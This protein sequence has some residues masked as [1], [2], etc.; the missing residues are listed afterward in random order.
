MNASL[1]HQ[2]WHELLP[3]LAN[4]TL[5]GAERARVEEHLASCLTCRSEL[6]AEQRLL[7]A[8]RSADAEAGQADD[9][10]V[11]ILARA[12]AAGAPRAALVPLPASTRRRW[13]QRIGQ[14]MARRVALVATLSAVALGLAHFQAGERVNVQRFHTLSEDRGRVVGADVL[15]VAFAPGVSIDSVAA[16]LRAVGAEVVSGPNQDHVFT[17]RVPSTAVASAV[18]TLAARDGVR[19]AAPATE[20]MPR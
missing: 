19:F 1:P 5:H 18:A 14:G 2:E 7:R 17:V 10:F 12:R 4:D 6:L 20:E 11:H 16:S 9:S 8:F 15:Y 13:G 3:F